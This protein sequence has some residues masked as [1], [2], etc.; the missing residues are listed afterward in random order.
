MQYNISASANYVQQNHITFPNDGTTFKPIAG[1]CSSGFYGI[2][3]GQRYKINNLNVNGGECTGGLFGVI[4]ANSVVR[5]V[6]L[7]GGTVRGLSSTGGLVGQIRGGMVEKSSTENMSVNGGPYHVGGFVG[8]I[9]SGAY[10]EECY[11]T[12]DVSASAYTGGFAGSMDLGLGGLSDCYAT[13]R[14]NGS[15]AG[16][17]I[18]LID[19]NTSISNAY[20]TGQSNK[21][22]FFGAKDPSAVL[23]NVYHLTG[24]GLP[25]TFVTPLILDDIAT[26]TFVGY[27]PIKWV[28][29][30]K[31]FPKLRFQLNDPS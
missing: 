24:N 25:S 6:R 1:N 2:F 11:S 20:A 22:G 4:E 7:V 19:V 8:R 17:F 26:N 28:L 27:V 14:V 12:S 13:G 16:G 5:N 30:S 31:S 21:G 10:V 23:Q 3:N 15:T 29:V 18:G 9:R